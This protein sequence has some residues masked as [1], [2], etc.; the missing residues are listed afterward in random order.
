MKEGQQPDPGREAAID[1]IQ[2][3]METYG[4]TV[5]DLRALGCFDAPPKPAA[6]VYMNAAGQVWDGTGEMPDWLKRAVNAGQSIEHFRV[7]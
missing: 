4:L 3:Q 2:E 7:N 6:P 5:E 1:W